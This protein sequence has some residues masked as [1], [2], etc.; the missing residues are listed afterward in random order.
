MADD[1][2]LGKTFQALTFLAWIRENRRAARNRGFQTISLGPNLIVAPTA[3]LDNWIEEA[4]RHLAPDAL[5][6][7]AKVFGAELRRFKNAVANDAADEGPLDTFKLGEFDWILTTYET[8]ADNHTSF[9]KI[10]FAV[11]VFDEIQKIK[12]PGTLNTWASKTVNADF[13]IGLTGTPVENRI[14]D[15]WS[16]MDRVFPGYLGDLK[17]FSKSYQLDEHALHSDL[18]EKYGLLKDKL[19]KSD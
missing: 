3:L 13:V 8:M 12:D 16:I 19:S 4:R 11:A 18:A 17:T 5:G 2:G 1:M 7:T 14:E 9:A 6:A 10:R 15:L